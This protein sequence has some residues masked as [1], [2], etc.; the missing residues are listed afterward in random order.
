MLEFMERTGSVNARFARERLNISDPQKT[1]E[2]LKSTGLQILTIA[3]PYKLNDGAV[4]H[5]VS[6]YVLVRDPQ[7][8]S[9]HDC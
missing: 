7:G 4:D 9:D 1:V 5:A 2:E 8:G 3:T 6:R